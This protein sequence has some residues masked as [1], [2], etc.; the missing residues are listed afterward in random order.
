MKRIIRKIL[1]E[2]F[3]NSRM[4]REEYLNKILNIMVDDTHINYTQKFWYPH[5]YKSIGSFIP[6]FN[7]PYVPESLIKQF[8][9]YSKENYGLTD[10]EIEYVFNE[11][12]NNIL[13]KIKYG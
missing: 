8:S 4:S 11:Y 1:K 12:R 9:E 2:E 6:T 7:F 10:D 13:S 5:F 3:L